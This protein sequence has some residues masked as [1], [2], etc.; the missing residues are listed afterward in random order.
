MKP[1]FVLALS[2]LVLASLSI[3]VSSQQSNLTQ[4]YGAG[5]LTQPN[6]VGP[7]LVIT[8]IQAWQVTATDLRIIFTVENIGNEDAI[9]ASGVAGAGP[10]TASGDIHVGFTYGALADISNTIPSL[11]AGDKYGFEVVVPY[12]ATAIGIVASVD[13]DDY[14]Q[15]ELYENNN[16]FK[17]TIPATSSTPAPPYG[18]PI[19]PANLGSGWTVDA[20]GDGW[21]VMD[22]GQGYNLIGSLLNFIGGQQAHPSSTIDL[23][24]DLDVI[25]ILDPLRQNPLQYPDPFVKCYPGV[26]KS[27][28]PQECQDFS[29]RLQNDPSYQPYT[30]SIGGFARSTISGQ[31]VFYIPSYSVQDLK[32]PTFLNTV[33]SQHNLAD[34]WTVLFVGPWFEGLTLDDVKG[35]CNFGDIYGWDAATKNWIGPSTVPL[36]QPAGSGDIGR[37]IL[38]EANGDCTLSYGTPIGGRPTLPPRS[39]GYATPY[40]T[41]TIQPTTGPDLV[42][43]AVDT[44]L[45]GTTFNIIVDITNIGVDDSPIPD[46]ELQYAGQTIFIDGSQARIVSGVGSPPGTPANVIAP[47]ATKVI[48]WD[49]SIFDPTARTVDAVVDPKDIIS[50]SEENN[51]IALTHTITGLPGDPCTSSSDCLKQYCTSN[52]V[53]S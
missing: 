43:D 15:N 23:T 21:L 6:T 49:Q 52:R 37:S 35:N 53:C 50:E 48:L 42:I 2:V 14:V 39:S 51:N 25:W 36:T 31:V 20:N 33:F 7:D 44:S 17:Y 34:G 18:L 8:D 12:D 24:Q 4:T 9:P 11:T 28:Q 40:P 10:R 22:I 32:D 30:L 26:S 46:I 16:A 3:L 1:Y 27:Q 47:G 19:P 41:A 5:N 13:P 45:A 29:D 38:V